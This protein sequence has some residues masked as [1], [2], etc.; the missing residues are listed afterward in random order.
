MDGGES[1]VFEPQKVH[2]ELLFSAN[3][4]SNNDQNEN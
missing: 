1:N 2:L 3:H 4:D